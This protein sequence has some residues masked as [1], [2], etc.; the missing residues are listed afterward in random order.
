MPLGKNATIYGRTRRRQSSW[1]RY[2]SKTTDYKRWVVVSA[3]GTLGYYVPNSARHIKRTVLAF[4]YKAQA[5]KMA[6]LLTNTTTVPHW[7]EE[8]GNA[9]VEKQK[10]H[11]E[12]IQK[13]REEQE[14]GTP[15]QP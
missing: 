11:N 9:D 6:A 7:S 8:R 14:N 4:R 1:V 5:D 12:Q 2:T 13:K 3:A 15:N 10:K